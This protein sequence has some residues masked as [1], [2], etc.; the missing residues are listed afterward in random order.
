MSRKKFVVADLCV[1]YHILL[2]HY[3]LATKPC[4]HFIM[5]ANNSDYKFGT[6]DTTND[7]NVLN[8]LGLACRNLVD[9]HDH[10][11]VWGNKKGKDSHVD[12]DVDIIDPYYK[13]MNVEWDRNKLVWN[14]A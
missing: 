7:P 12:L 6:L 8:T 3:Y 11:K 2:Y 13:D 5:F 10:Y 1:C 9:I 14:R 4:E